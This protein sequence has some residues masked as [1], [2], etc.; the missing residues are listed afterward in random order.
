M[1]INEIL[2]KIDEDNPDWNKIPDDFFSIETQGKLDK[3]NVSKYCILN[4]LFKLSDYRKEKES[5]E[6]VDKTGNY[7]KL[8]SFQNSEIVF[9]LTAEFINKYV[10][11]KSRTRDQMEQAARSGKQNIIEGSM[12]SRVSRRTEMK[13][14]N[15]ARA[16]LDELL[17]DYEDYVRVN[18]GEVWGL[19]HSKAKEVR[20]LAYKTDRT[21][22]TYEGYMTSGVVAANALICLI[23]Q[24]NYLLDKQLRAQ[25]KDYSKNGGFQDRVDKDRR[26]NLQK[27]LWT[28]W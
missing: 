11:Y 4:T 16:S 10:S 8:K 20:N 2:D 17:A 9:D 14:T 19:N 28:R 12:A 3:R 18:G 15:V 24:T 23:H 13:L 5:P 27:R 6:I 25:E 21:S 1:D 22:K 26:K 7:R